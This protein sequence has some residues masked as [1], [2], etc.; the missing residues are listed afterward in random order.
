M[1]VHEEPVPYPFGTPRGLELVPAYRQAREGAGLTRVRLP[2][3][4]P[5]WLA[6]RYE[7]VKAV[8]VDPRFSRAAVV[9]PD[10]PRVLLA[11]NTPDTLLS[12][13]PPEHTRVR[14]VVAGAF[15]A[16]RVE[17]LREWTQGVAEEMVDA[18]RRQGPP[19]DLIESLAMPLPIT[20]LC[21][22]LGVVYTDRARFREWSSTLLSTG[23]RSPEEVEAA[24]REIRAYVSELVALRRD[25]PGDDLISA[26]VHMRDTEDRLTEREL[27]GL[28][29]AI[30]VAGYETTANTI[31]NMSYTLLANPALFDQ[32]RATP[33]LI[34]KAVEELLRAL[35]LTVPAA[36]FARMATEDVQIG[37][38]LVK[39]GESVLPGSMA[40][41]QDEAVFPDARRVDFSRANA[42]A[43]LAFGHGVH[44]CLGAQLARMELRVAIGTLVTRLPGLRLAVPAEEITWRSGTIIRAISSLPVT[45]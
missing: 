20:V 19:A 29:L 45:W 26:L 6:T 13:D 44:H 35:P 21:Q 31:V 39:A 42:G 5:A 38:T 40:A 1:V 8:L 11:P 14:R 18:V 3:G 43:H 10:E 17:R 30:L 22:L 9:G 2:F 32:I 36:L 27:V 25:Q 33:E 37:A 34:P 28:S 41:N 7:D 23:H 4:P 15:T 24:E 12:M 16:R